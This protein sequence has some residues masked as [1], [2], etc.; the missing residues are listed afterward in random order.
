MNNHADWEAEFIPCSH[1]KKLLTKLESLNSEFSH[2][3]D[4]QLIKK[5]I[6]FAKKYH[7][8]QSRQSG[9][10]YYSHLL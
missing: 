5:S 1:S 2:P 4:I 3:M 10:P 7:E 6:Y 9:E 8:G